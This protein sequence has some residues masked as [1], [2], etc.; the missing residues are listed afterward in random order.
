M[1]RWEP[2]ARERLEQAA[3]ELYGEHGFDQTTVAEIAQRAGLTERTFFRHFADKREVLFWGQGALHD[4][5]VSTV[6]NAPDSVAPIDAIGAALEAAGDP[7]EERRHHAQ[8]R[9]VVIAANPG[10]QEREL[11]KL[12]SLAAAMA[13]AL[14]QRGVTEPAA[15][16]TAE[17]GIAVFKVAFERWLDDTNQRTFSQ[18]IRESLDELKAV[19]A[20][21][22]SP[23]SRR[24]RGH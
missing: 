11:I 21:T 19:T 13:D 7:F 1:S 23:L 12:A 20:G 5:L 22:P 3:L 24:T 14:R 15:T 18:L 2:K 17:A 4:G 8:Q 9:Q 16:L 6:A 10:L